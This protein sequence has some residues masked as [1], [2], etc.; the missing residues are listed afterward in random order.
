MMDQAIL[1]FAFATA[2]ASAM[3]GGVF[4]GFSSFVMAALARVP[5]GAAISA[6]QS[7]NVVVL[8]SWLLR[9]FMA[10]AV[11][12]A[13]LAVI[14]VATWQQPGSLSLI[15]GSLVYLAGCLGVTM[16]ANVPLNNEL[17][18]TKAE[19]EEGAKVWTRYLS[20][21]TAWNHVRTIACLA[22]AILL[23]IA[24]AQRL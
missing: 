13:A 6:M 1:I 23:L 10:A 21:W 11:A 7:I 8:N 24:V 15:A 20:Q 19:S 18:A 2:L 17:A 16:L 3:V 5:I 9:T 4:F 12:C 22:A 14:A